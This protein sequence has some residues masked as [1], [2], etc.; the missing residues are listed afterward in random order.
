MKKVRSISPEIHLNLEYLCKGGEYPP[1]HRVQSWAQKSVVFRKYW[2]E[3][4]YIGEKTS[5]LSIY[6]FGTEGLL[7]EVRSCVSAMSLGLAQ[8]HTEKFIL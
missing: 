2:I 8:L 3:A 7:F 1:T 5:S 6:T 4:F